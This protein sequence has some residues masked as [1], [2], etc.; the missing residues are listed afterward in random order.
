[1]SFHRILYVSRARFPTLSSRS[2]S[3][4]AGSRIYEAPSMLSR[5]LAWYTSKLESSPLLT[6]GITSGLIAAS[7]DLLCQGVV[8]RNNN[9]QEL[10][11]DGEHWWDVMRTVRFGFLGAA[12]VGPVIHYWFQALN[13]R[14]VPGQGLA[15]IAKRVALDQFVF[16]PIFLPI[17]MTSLWSL[18]EPN[19]LASVPQRLKDTVPPII[20]MNWMLW[21]P[22]QGIN[23]RFVPVHY[24]VLYSNVVGLLWN[25]YLSYSTRASSTST[26]TTSSTT[27]TTVTLPTASLELVS[28]EVEAPRMPM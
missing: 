3:T 7:G 9:K 19:R 28:K 5:M 1:M 26:T 20:L 24:Q 14:L 27:T 25:T 17:W 13:F 22:A 6:K 18:E 10:L 8:E 11:Q 2:A 4:T 12:L 21:V 15:V 16:T 23:F